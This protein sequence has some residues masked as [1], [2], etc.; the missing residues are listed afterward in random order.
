MAYYIPPPKD[1]LVL[2]CVN[3]TGEWGCEMK[4]SNLF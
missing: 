1:Q 2:V 3:I 4:G